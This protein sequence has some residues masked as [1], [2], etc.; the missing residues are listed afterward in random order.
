MAKNTILMI[1]DGLGWEMARAAAIQKQINEGNKSDTLAGFYTSGEGT[2][3]NFQ[4]LTGYQTVTTYGTTIA[5]A[6]G[7]YSDGI[8]TL[9]KTADKATGAG[10]P[11][12][13]FSFD[14]TFNPGI[15]ATGGAKVADGVKG[16]LVGYDPVKGGVNPWTPGTDKEYIKYSYP[17]SA[18]TATTLY[19]GV[20]SYNGA[21][22]VD[23]F[24]KPLD[25]ILKQ[26]SDL[27]KSTGLVTSV[28]IDHATPGAAAANVN[29]RN[30]YDTNSANATALDNILQQELRVYQ[31]TVLLGGGHPLSNTKDPLPAGVEPVR[32]NADNTYISPETYAKLV[33]DPTNNEYGYTFLERGKDAAT[34]LANTAKTINPEKQKLLGLYG[35]RGQ[36]GNLPVSSANGDYSTTGLA[37][38]TNNSTRGLT[39]DTV[40]PLLPG[41]TDASFIARERNENP[42]LDDLTKASL[43]VLGKDNDGFWLMIEGGDID[44]AAHDNNIDNLI[45]ATLD[46]DKAVGSVV[47][48][49][50][51]HGGWEQNELIVTADHDHYLT[52]S[53]NF[54]KLLRE[55]G[56]EKLTE[57]DTSVEAG[58][59]WG[60][61]PVVAKDAAGKEL[62]ETGK[63]GWGNHSNRPVPVYFQGADTQVI[64]DSVGKG[65][66]NYGFQV[67][68]V[69]GLVDQ[70]A[71]YQ[72]QAQGVKNLN[73]STKSLEVY[74][75]TT[76]PVVGTTALA[77]SK[78]ITKTTVQQDI[79]LGGFSGLQFTGVAANGNLRF[80]TVTDR[81]PNGATADFLKD[82]PGDELPVILP[83]FQ[84]EIVKF[85]LNRVSGQFAITQRI[86]LTKADGQAISGLPN[87]QA[88]AQGLAY[89]DPV[90]VD[91]FGN[92]LNNDPLGGDFEGIA[93]DSDGSYWLADEYRPSIYHFSTTGKLIERL[94]PKGVST[95]AKF[96]T[97]VLP[98]VYAQRRGN[99]GFEGI[100]IEGNKIYA[101]IQS[102]IDNPDVA[103]D[104]NSK[105]SANLRILEYDKSTK[106]V[107]GEY[108]YQLDNVKTAEKIGDLASLGN[109]KFV[110]VER[111]D[112]GTADSVKKIYEIDLSKATNISVAANLAGIPVGKTI[113][114][115]TAAELTTAK[116]QS[117]T[118]KLVAD[119][120]ALGYTGVEK[121]EGLAV[122]DSKTI[123]VINDNDF[124]V[125]ASV[126]KGDGSITGVAET[127]TKLGI[128]NLATPLSTRTATSK[129]KDLRLYDADNI[130]ETGR[131][132]I[133]K[134]K[135]LSR[136]GSGINDIGVVLVDD[137]KG[138]I[139]GV[140]PGSADYLKT[141]L[142]KSQSVFSN[143]IGD[144]FEAG[145]ER[146]LE[147]DFGKR[148]QFF[149]VQDSTIAQAQ[150]DLKDGKTPAKILFGNKLANGG[151]DAAKITSDTD[152]FKIGWNDAKNSAG[153]FQDLVL[154][155]ESADVATTV[156]TGT[157]LQ[158]LAE[159]RVVDLRGQ[160][161]AITAK[162]EAKS[163]ADFN[164]NFAFYEVVDAAG[165]LTNGK[166]VGDADYAKDAVKNAVFSMSKNASANQ[167][168]TGGKIY[169]PVLIANGTAD[170]F[171]AANA[172][173]T[174]N[175]NLPIAYFNY[176]G[177]NTD[178]VDHFRM[179]GDNQFGVE[180]LYGGGDMDFNDVVIKFTF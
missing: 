104:A 46:F 172:T 135:A 131:D 14:P 108:I 152:V 3:L 180:D 41:E 69:A 43:E 151:S 53:D 7:V 111:D 32:N 160:I 101:V 159:G 103:N 42:T 33:K 68:G 2:G 133:V 179:L 154:Q 6:A 16:N 178:K 110:I 119:A 50:N 78:D 21:I 58:H 85:E 115:L 93:I 39:P 149:S 122:L 100:A 105:A 114:Q 90:P 19:T 146:R 142:S 134:I 148:L 107:T 63:Y 174:G 34:V 87:L 35:A 176:V 165:T 124:G 86:G 144:F 9:D 113:E 96:G 27:G 1:G 89:T 31:P 64:N 84:P 70:T 117:V 88:Q 92:K 91:L 112:V 17:D 59:Y 71:L 173:N 11:L 80:V 118:K 74:D 155:V 167:T 143:L 61:N 5:N 65:Y 10:N 55:Q 18:N 177:A 129:A 128:L 45:G 120:A 36:D 40:R 97:A 171:L 30:K 79:K 73:K 37:M 95:D 123:A 169:A 4:K 126:I 102:P 156:I 52:L 136:G 147:V 38:F 125:G 48:W 76:L 145:R 132:Q 47:S 15:N 116:I 8:S 158:T 66:L 51:A 77:N 139:N 137:D 140:L 127:P 60:S 94:I 141:L 153:S 150:Q 82:I 157:K 67:P 62:T 168:L 130:L 54:P 166:K 24:E 121:L 75:W 98:E 22:S 49:I 164:N 72:A 170:S 12:T 99:R 83:N 81:G 57:I 28:P 138:S 26:A 56:A 23:I 25:T 109:G 13:G 20:K 44:W 163:S 29:S 161:G 162:V 106:A 175:G